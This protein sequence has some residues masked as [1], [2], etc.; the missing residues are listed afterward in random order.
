MFF[1]FFSDF[2]DFFCFLV[3]IGLQPFSAK[4]APLDH[5]KNRP[6][7]VMPQPNTGQIDFG[8]PLSVNIRPPMAISS[9]LPTREAAT[10]PQQAPHWYANQPN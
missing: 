6:E 2:S 9:I 10:Q 1:L 8:I 3:F 7:P 5:T 4:N